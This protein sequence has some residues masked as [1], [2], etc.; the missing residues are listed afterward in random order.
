MTP[1]RP[2]L[3]VLIVDDQ[4]AIRRVVRAYVETVHRAEGK[5][6][7]NGLEAVERLLAEDFDLVITD[8]LMPEMSGLELVGYMRKTPRLRLV[9]VVML[10][11]QDEERDRRRAASFGV[12]DY[13]LKPFTPSALGPALEKYLK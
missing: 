1:P 10:T 8:L 11:S 9:P 12:A 3:R 4:A 6:A 13:L 7:A 5:E 2:A